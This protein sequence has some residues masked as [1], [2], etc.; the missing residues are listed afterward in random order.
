M[1]KKPGKYA[2]V[3]HKLTKIV[4][5][6]PPAYQDRVELKKTE[7]RE[8]VANEE[9]PSVTLAK[10]YAQLRF[11]LAENKAQQSRLNLELDACVQLLVDQQERGAS[12]W[13][14]YG[15]SENTMRLVSGDALRVAAEPYTIFENK[16]E[17]RDHFMS[18]DLKRL[19]SPPWVTVNSLNKQR[20]LNG[21]PP[22][23][24]TKLYIKTT[25]EFTPMKPET[26]DEVTAAAAAES[27]M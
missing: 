21:E 13:G 5:S 15:A 18:G 2:G 10:R 6:E 4:S 17:I 7:L 20:L 14:E 3:M 19:L 26:V 12:G 25:I 24:G 22:L 8:A 27:D 9:K 11:A 1:A 23:P 16:D